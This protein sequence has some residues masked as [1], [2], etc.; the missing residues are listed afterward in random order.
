M[1]Q[2]QITNEAL[3]PIK[4]I[5]TTFEIPVTRIEQKTNDKGDTVSW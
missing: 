2:L 3:V 4:K 1:L 5:I